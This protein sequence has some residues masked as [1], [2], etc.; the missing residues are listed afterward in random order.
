M[1]ITYLKQMLQTQAGAK[2]ATTWS[3]MPCQMT[4][5]LLNGLYDAA[6]TET[7]KGCA[8]CLCNPD[9]FTVTDFAIS[10]SRTLKD[11]EH[12]LRIARRTLGAASQP[13]ISYYNF[14]IHCI[15]LPHLTKYNA[16]LLSAVPFFAKAV[17]VNAYDEVVFDKLHDIAQKQQSAS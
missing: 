15:R 5:Y 10:N 9:N 17:H 14:Q 1:N 8:A 2:V 16:L 3:Y 11:L 4:F 12:C 13:N 7:Q 6:V